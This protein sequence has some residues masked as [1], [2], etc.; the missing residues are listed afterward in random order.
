MKRSMRCNLKGKTALLT[1]GRTKI[2]F[3]IALALLRNGAEVVVTTR[4]PKSAAIKFSKVEDYND[5][6][7]NLIIF[8]VDLKLRTGILH[9]C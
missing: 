4:F 8:G 1:G 5:W 3:E 6:K 7:S 9:L 2:G